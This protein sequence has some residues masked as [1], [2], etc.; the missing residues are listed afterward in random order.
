MFKYFAAAI[1]MATS[2]LAQPID[3]TAGSD[4]SL[5][6]ARTQVHSMDIAE[7]RTFLDVVFACSI[8]QEPDPNSCSRQI[9]R[10]QFEYRGQRRELGFFLTYWEASVRYAVTSKPPLAYLRNV[11]TK[12]KEAAEQQLYLLRKKHND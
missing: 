9:G 2:A 3:F 7:L 11:E 12:L 8:D 1:F 5:E 6:F 10:Y 4:R